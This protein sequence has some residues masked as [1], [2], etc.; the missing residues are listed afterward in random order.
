MQIKEFQIT[1]PLTVEEYQVGQLYA[2]AEHSKAETGG[3]D[4][5][6]IVKN[7]PFENE[8][9]GSGQYTQKIYHLQHKVPGWI[10]KFAPSGSLQVMEEAWNAY[11]Y[12]KT[13][14]N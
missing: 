6:E 1:L 8:E 13:V 9:H 7:E 2:V 3:G 4:G 12:C 14:P 11:P 5:V 10:R